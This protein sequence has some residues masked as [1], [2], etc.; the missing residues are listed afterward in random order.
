M[1]W[2]IGKDMS[3]FSALA[4]AL[5]DKLS[6]K[7]QQVDSLSDEVR[8]T[9]VLVTTL[10]KDIQDCNNAIELMQFTNDQMDDEYKVE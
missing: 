3:K 7:K 5:A 9:Q 2:I 6:L 4:R 1:I 10:K 8:D